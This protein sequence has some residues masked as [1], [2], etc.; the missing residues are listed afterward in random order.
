MPQLNPT[1]NALLQAV[2]AFAIDRVRHVLATEPARFISYGTLVALTSANA[3][4]HALGYNELPDG[5]ANGVTLLAAAMITE[6]I[7]RFVSPANA[8]AN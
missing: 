2:K 3:I 6:A 1:A 8:V 5:I 4:G 7:R